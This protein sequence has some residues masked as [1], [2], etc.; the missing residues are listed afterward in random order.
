MRAATAAS[1][2]EADARNAIRAFERAD[3]AEAERQWR[4]VA[5][6][7]PDMAL[8]RANLAT[9]SVI[10]A[11]DAMT[12]G[13]WSRLRVPTGITMFGGPLRSVFEFSG[14]L[15]PGDQGE[16]L[17]TGWLAQIGTGLEFD[18]SETWV[19][20]VTRTRIM[21]RYTQGEELTG[22]S[23]GLAASF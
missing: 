7:Y 14:S 3:Y 8:P 18:T 9:C 1:T 21:L 4:A 20:L 11:S 15:L 23:V 17:H 10:V 12:L 5:T 6:S 13:L 16:V 22:F 2:F 19:P